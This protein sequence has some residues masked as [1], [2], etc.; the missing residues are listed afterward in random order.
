MSS[1]EQ[2]IIRIENSIKESLPFVIYSEPGLGQAKAFF[3]PADSSSDTEPFSGNSFVFA[4]YS[5]ED[6]GL[7]LDCDRSEVLLLDPMELSDLFSKENNATNPIS[8]Q[9]RIA[10]KKLVQ[11]ALSLINFRMAKKVVTSR[12]VTIPVPK[13]NWHML[14]K[15]LFGRYPDAFAYIWYHPKSGIWCGATPEL[16]VQTNGLEFHTM[17]LAGTRPY[18]QYLPVDWSEKEEEEQRL[19]VDFIVNRLQKVT[20]VV[21]LSKT[22]SH[23]AGKVVHLRTDIS[24]ILK[25]NKTTLSSLVKTLH[26][27]SAICGMPRKLSAKF[28]QENEGYD[29][30][31]YTG[32]LGPFNSNNQ[33]GQLFVNLR[34]MQLEADSAHIYVGGGITKASDP[35]AEWLETENKKQTML[36]VLSSML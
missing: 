27:T 1:L 34:C 25:K 30:E 20:S 15:N 8:E 23:R 11:D 7:F 12:K 22:R 9:E 10:Y 18:E 21:K 28:L 31:F 3:G 17:A 16:L 36:D 33:T 29:R 35:E 2:L 5:Y 4:P 26:P 32:F 24:G 13:F 14:I 19:V 6:N